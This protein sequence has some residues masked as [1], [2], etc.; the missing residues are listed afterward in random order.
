MRVE[1]ESWK[2]QLTLYVQY[3]GLVP[4][5]YSKVFLDPRVTMVFIQVCN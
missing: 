5:L 3:H 4:N 1:V 2:K